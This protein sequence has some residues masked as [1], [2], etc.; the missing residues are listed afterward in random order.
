MRVYD[1][2]CDVC[3]TGFEVWQDNEG[4]GDKKCPKCESTETYQIPSYAGYH[5][6]GSSPSST[7]PR[8][9]GAFKKAKK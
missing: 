4:N 3:N 6:Y 5:M 9:A 1:Y 8:G 7:R 2:R